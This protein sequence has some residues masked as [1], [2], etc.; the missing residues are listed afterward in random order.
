MGFSSDSFG[1]PAV[2]VSQLAENGDSVKNPGDFGVDRYNRLK[3]CSAAE[4]VGGLPSAE[5]ELRTAKDA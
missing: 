5:A 1:V 2:H 4:C 3:R